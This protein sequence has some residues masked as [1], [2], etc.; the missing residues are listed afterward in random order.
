MISL[1]KKILDP[2]SS[3]ARRMIEYGKTD[4][5]FILVPAP[6]KNQ[7]DLS[8]TVHVATTG[9][10]KLQQLWRLRGLGIDSIKTQK[11]KNTKTLFISTQDPFFIGFVGLFIKQQT[12]VPLEVQLHGDF[13][14]SDYYR[15]SGLKN[16]FQYHLGK[17]VIARADRVRVVGERVRES[18]IRLGV[19]PEKIVVR[20]VA[21][22]T[23]RIEEQAPAF[24]L[25]KKYAEFKKIFLALGRLEVVKNLAWLIRFWGDVVAKEPRFLLLIVGSGGERQTIEGLVK[26][27]NLCHNIIF[28]PWTTDPWSYLKTADALLFPSISEGYGLVVREAIAAGLPV[29]MNDVGVANYEVPASDQ[30]TIVPINDAGAWQAAIHKI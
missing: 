26:K 2:S 29:I 11:H 3:V 9:G 21:V 12:G 14:S 17:R 24:D 16:W 27:L 5:L 7:F 10:R 1:D 28:E 30:A 8:A 15:Q 13:Y 4:E 22:D 20:P 18:V 6:E 25:H 23:K 19:L